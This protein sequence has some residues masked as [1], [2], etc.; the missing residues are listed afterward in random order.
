MHILR[1]ILRVGGWV[2]GA[3]LGSYVID[4]TLFSFPL[5]PFCS[6]RNSI[7]ATVY[8]YSHLTYAY[9]ST[10]IDTKMHVL[11]MREIEYKEVYNDVT[12]FWLSRIYATR[13]IR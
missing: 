8:I 5:C 10:H 4:F 13:R 9:I 3:F 11:Y 6:D 1:E 12:C 7:F 2:C